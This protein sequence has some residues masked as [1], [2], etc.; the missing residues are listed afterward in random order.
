EGY[1]Q[2]VG[3]AGRDGEPSETVMLVGEADARAL[4]QFAVA[5]VPTI[6]DLRRTYRVVRASGGTVDPESIA[7]EVPDAD[8]RVLVGMLDQAGLVRRG[9]D[10]GRT[11]RV[12]A[13]PAPADAAERIERLLDRLARGAAERAERII[14]FGREDR[15]RHRQVAEHFGEQL[16]HACGAC[17]VCEPT[18]SRHRRSRAASPLPDDVGRTIVDAVSALAWP[19]GRKSLVAMLRGSQSAPPS[20]RRNG[21]FG[22]L[23][24]ASESEVTRWVRALESGGALEAFESEEGYRLLRSRP[25]AE[26]PRLRAVPPATGETDPGLVARLRAW[27]LERARQDG[28]PPYIILHDRTLD[29]LAALRPTTLDELAGVKGLGPAKLDRYGLALLDLCASGSPPMAGGDEGDGDADPVGRPRA[30]SHV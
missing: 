25:G 20:A 15:C 21:A 26:I 1:V 17:D 3:R 16:D 9:Y 13:P 23:A 14:R 12:E 7:R 4:R 11:M 2:M 18:G 6:D 19:L 5:D 28:M 22:V 10:E 24:A 27:R 8:P 29:E 30:A